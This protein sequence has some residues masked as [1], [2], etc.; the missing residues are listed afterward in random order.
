MWKL[1]SIAAG[2]LQARRSQIEARKCYRSKINND[3]LI[4]GTIGL[5]EPMREADTIR[6]L[7][8][9]QRCGRI[10]NVFQSV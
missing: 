10:Y 3:D 8:M 4:K 9:S 7:L 5:A 2:V 6:C 1:A